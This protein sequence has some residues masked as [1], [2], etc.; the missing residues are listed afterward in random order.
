MNMGTMGMAELMASLGE[1]DDGYSSRHP[2]GEHSL[3]GESNVSS[4]DG[5]LRSLLHCLQRER[6]A[7]S[8]MVASANTQAGVGLMVHKFRFETDA[9]VETIHL[10]YMRATANAIV[11]HREKV[12]APPTS[13]PVAPCPPHPLLPWCHVACPPH[14]LLPWC[15]VA[16]GRPPA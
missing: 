9:A 5:D 3:S 8:A 14:P 2:G 1:V 13:L 7:T 4:D 10:S 6:G 12:D 11:R 15:H 16:G